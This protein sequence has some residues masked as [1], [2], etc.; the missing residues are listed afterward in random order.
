MTPEP[1]RA[2]S[3]TR[4]RRFVFSH[5]DPTVLP[6]CCC[7]VRRSARSVRCEDAATLAQGQVVGTGDDEAY[8]AGKF[9]AAL[10]I[11]QKIVELTPQAANTRISMASSR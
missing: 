2:E 6:A 4:A 8:R 5:A 7:L 9:D 11:C 10:S 3:E 1:K